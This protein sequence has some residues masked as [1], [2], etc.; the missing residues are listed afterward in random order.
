MEGVV[1]TDCNT[2]NGLCLTILFRHP[3]F[4]GVLVLNIYTAFACRV[5]VCAFSRPVGIFN[6]WSWLAC[7][8]NSVLSLVC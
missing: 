3:L 2:M 8:F 4:S 1:R 6:Y 7:H 5:S